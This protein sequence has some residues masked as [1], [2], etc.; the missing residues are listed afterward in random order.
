MSRH[1]TIARSSF[2]L[3]KSRGPTGVAPDFIQEM[4]SSKSLLMLRVVEV[5]GLAEQPAA[6]LAKQLRRTEQIKVSWQVQVKGFAMIGHDIRVASD[7]GVDFGWLRHLFLHHNKLVDFLS[8]EKLHLESLT[9]LLLQHNDLQCKF[10]PFCQ[11]PGLTTLYLHSN[12]ISGQLPAC[13]SRL[14]NLRV[15]TLHQNQLTGQ[16]PESLAKWDDL[17]V[18]TLHTNRLT[19]SIPQQFASSK[20]LAFFS[21]YNNGLTGRI[22]EL[23]LTNGCAD[24]ESMEEIVTVT[25][26][27]GVP[28]TERAPCRRIEWLKALAR[29]AD[30]EWEQVLSQHPVLKAGCPATLGL[31]ANASARGPTLLLHGNRLSCSLP[32][33]VTGAPFDLRSLVLIGNALGNQSNTLPS[34]VA[35]TEQQPFLY[36]S[37][38]T[39]RNVG[40][41]FIGFALLCSGV[42]FGVIGSWKHLIIERT[43]EDSTEISHIFVI[44]ASWLFAPLAFVLLCLYGS[45]YSYYACG[46]PFLASSMAYFQGDSWEQCFLCFG[47]ILWIFGSALQLR[48]VPKPR[49]PGK[50]PSRG[51]VGKLFGWTAWFCLVLFLSAPSMAY[52]I[53]STLPAQN[54]IITGPWL[55]AIKHQAALVMLLVESLSAVFVGMPAVIPID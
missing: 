38:P 43:P 4:S 48:M 29:N 1:E 9:V 27:G 19:G 22:P 37:S 11:V 33:E 52:A 2:K 25:I 47:W 50:G 24:D 55:W 14:K 26:A 15:L 45:G 8:G 18:L 21:A 23:K 46:D 51:R 10:D 6:S 12:R 7:V 20:N 28:L 54:V 30:L 34:W 41:R 53:A 31:C 40:L 44:E 17:K 32:S 39:V 42:W 3:L 36:V 13:T 16:I 35:E 5:S 49:R